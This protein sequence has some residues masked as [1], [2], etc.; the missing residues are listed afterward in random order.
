M[1]LFVLRF[2]DGMKLYKGVMPG[3]EMPPYA[4]VNNW[5]QPTPLEGSGFVGCAGAP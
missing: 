2:S 5:G 3:G 4:P 1:V